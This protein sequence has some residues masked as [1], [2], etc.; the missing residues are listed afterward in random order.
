M[1]SRDDPVLF[2]SPRMED[3][4]LKSAWEQSDYV[5]KY[6]GLNCKN[7]QKCPTAKSCGG[8]CRS[9]AYTE[10]GELDSPD[11]LSCNAFKN[12]TSTYV[13]FAEVYN[14]GTSSL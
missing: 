11:F 7:T 2:S 5:L 3:Y 1:T 6:R 9:N 4:S 13:D 14:R 12:F 10:T 8:G